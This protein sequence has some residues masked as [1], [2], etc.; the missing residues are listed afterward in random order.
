MHEKYNTQKIIYSLSQFNNFKIFLKKENTYYYDPENSIDNIKF[1]NETLLKIK[2]EY[3][4]EEKNKEKN[5]IRI[6]GINDSL[7]LLYNDDISRYFIEGTYKCAPNTIKSSNVLI[8][9][10]AYKEKLKKFELCLVSTFTKKDKET[11]IQFYLNLKSK[12]KFIPKKISCNFCKSNMEAI[13]SVYGE[14]NVLIIT[15]FFHLIQCW[16]GKANKLGMRKKNVI[17]KSR[18]LIFNLKLLPFMPLDKAREFYFSIKDYFD[19]EIFSNFYSY[20]EQTWLNLEDKDPVKYEFK[21]WTYFEK[22]DF[23]NEEKSF[24]F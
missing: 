12:F 23:K 4:K 8:I 24:N 7:K 10:I 15:C 19:E 13:K 17:H 14:E 18:N 11:Y 5:I 22:F 20:F 2:I 6:Y 21:I 16:W 1:E 3:K 9:L